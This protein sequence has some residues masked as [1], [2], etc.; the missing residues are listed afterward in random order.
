M[1]KILR[2]TLVYIR[3]YIFSLKVLWII[4]NA[5]VFVFLYKFPWHN[6]NLKIQVLNGSW[7]KDLPP[8]ITI[9]ELK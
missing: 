7:P 9:T 1:I 6:R 3:C 8:K 5:N 4:S 2:N